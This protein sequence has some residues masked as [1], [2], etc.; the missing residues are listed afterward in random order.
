MY[1]ND[2]LVLDEWLNDSLNTFNYVMGL[3]SNTTP[4]RIVVEH[5]HST[6]S[7]RLQIRWQSS[8]QTLAEIGPSTSVDPTPA[9]LIID[10]DKIQRITYLSVGKE[11]PDI[12]TPTN[13]APPGD[14]IVIRSV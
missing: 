10:S 1:I 7:Q 8:S 12:T 11:M 6:G 3:L 9:P 4:Q 5:F 14:K 13:G 2:V